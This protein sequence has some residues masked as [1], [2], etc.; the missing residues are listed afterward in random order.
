MAFLPGVDRSNQAFIFCLHAFARRGHSCASPSEKFDLLGSRWA[1][2][3]LFTISSIASMLYEMPFLRGRPQRAIFIGTF[4][5]SAILFFSFVSFQ[6]PK[7][8]GEQARDWASPLSRPKSTVGLVKD[9]YNETLGVFLRHCL[10]VDIQLTATSS[11]RFW[12]S[13]CP[14]GRITRIPSFYL[15]LWRA[16]RVPLWTAWM[17]KTYLKKLCLQTMAN[18]LCLLEIEAVGE[19]I[20]TPFNGAFLDI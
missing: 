16:S 12:S 1:L 10:R 3:L 15:L 18:T 4:V 2:R 8:P 6:Y 20:L 7:L 13:I 5:V 17:A 19:H 11:R 14:L 9:I